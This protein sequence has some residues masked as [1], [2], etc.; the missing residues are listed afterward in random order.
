MKRLGL[1]DNFIQHGSRD[2]ILKTINLDV[3]GI[4]ENVEKLLINKKSTI[5]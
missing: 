3:D 4:V 2:E 5:I 1:P